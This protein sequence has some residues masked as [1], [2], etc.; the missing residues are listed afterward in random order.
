MASEET[1]PRRRLVK[2]E[3]KYALEKLLGLSL[4]K[5]A[6]QEVGL[7][8]Q[9]V[10]DLG[11][12]VTKM[13]N[14]QDFLTKRNKS[15]STEAE[16][17]TIRKTLRRLRD[18]NDANPFSGGMT[19]VESAPSDSR[20]VPAP[21]IP[22]QKEPPIFEIEEIP[23]PV[24]PTPS[25]Q[26]S[27]PDGQPPS[28]PSSKPARPAVSAPSRAPAQRQPVA[29]KA[30][31]PATAEAPAAQT[32]PPSP[33]ILVERY[34]RCWNLKAFAPEYDCFVP[35]RLGVSKETY[36]DRR[37][38]TWLASNYESM[39]LTQELGNILMVRI[40]GHKANVLC[41]RVLSDSSKQT[42]FLELYDLQDVNGEWK[43]YSVDAGIA[44]NELLVKQMAKATG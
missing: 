16:M 10:D 20:H 26:E 29:Q 30:P 13:K 7:I 15:A 36:V 6:D 2:E 24:L 4:N 25:G 19:R 9:L 5:L 38:A 1:Q 43:I 39:N 23:L 32:Q 3:Q 35:G 34:I 33:A 28:V 11:H 14:L 21:S 42:T 22:D 17:D 41:T 8:Q 37:M 18:E 31:K 27:A 44:S 40:K 12:D